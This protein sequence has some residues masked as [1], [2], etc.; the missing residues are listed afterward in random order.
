MKDFFTVLSIVFLVSFFVWFFPREENNKEKEHSQKKEDIYMEDKVRD[1]MLEAKEIDYVKYDLAIIYPERE[2]Q[3]SFWQ[4]KEKMKMKKVV[5]G[6][7]VVLFV[8]S[9]KEIEQLHLPKEN[10]FTEITK[11]EI[12]EVLRGS[13]KNHLAILLREEYFFLGSESIN[14]KDC[15]VIESDFNQEKKKVWLSKEHGFPIKIKEKGMIIEA[16]N[17]DFNGDKDVFELPEGS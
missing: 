14:E 13:L 10:I 3:G 2:V 6:K 9:R 16:E 5:S 15:F 7:E 1:L 17:F 12:K 8:D 4:K 11:N